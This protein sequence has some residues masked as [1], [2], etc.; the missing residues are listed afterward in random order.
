MPLSNC[1]NHPNYDNVCNPFDPVKWKGG[2]DLITDRLLTM[3]EG[4]HLG[5][6]NRMQ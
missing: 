6:N 2:E 1:H 5:H 3:Q 4:R